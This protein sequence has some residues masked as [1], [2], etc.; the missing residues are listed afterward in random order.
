MINHIRGKQVIILVGDVIVMFVALFFA[1]LIRYL[2][3]PNV[4][5]WLKHASIFAVNFCVWVTFFYIA[6]VYNLHSAIN[7]SKFI[8][9]SLKAILACSLF[10]IAFFYSYT[11]TNIS[12][13]TTLALYFGLFSILYFCWRFYI[14]RILAIRV[15]RANIAVIGLTK[16][17]S[18]VIEETTNK[19]HLGYRVK[20]ILDEN[21]NFKNNDVEVLR[22]A[23]EFEEKLNK[24]KITEIVIAEDFRNSEG[25]KIILFNAL[26]RNINFANI[27]TFYEELMGK[28]H[29][30]LVD[31][32]WFL[33]NFN[34]INNGWY[35]FFKRIF[36]I[37]VSLIILVLTLPLWIIVAVIIKSDSKGPI[38]FVDT[39][40][41]KNQKPFKLA[42]FRTMSINNNDQSPTIKNNDTRITRIGRVLRK[43]RIDELP[44][45]L[46]VIKGEMSIVGPRPERPM[47]VEKLTPVIPYYNIR[48]LIEPGIT[49]W[50]Q[51]SGEYHSPSREDTIKKLQYD[52]FYI[53]NRSIYLDISILL[54]TIKTVLSSAGV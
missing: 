45:L 25:T 29:L 13:K 3:L 22:N 24:Y 32:M 10:T 35:G 41:G 40:L 4:D 15:P 11:E 34:R 33:E 53:K 1:L 46:S 19:P 49:G 42:K 16:Q 48:M 21:S 6:G 43:T 39:R 9:L 51:V 5:L 14:N 54:K 36:D 7:N 2:E 26:R 50:D 23:N 17:I 38:F 37:V 27:A 18:E 12:P 31:K 47:L 30:D 52:F 8:E 28:I 20:L 44:Q